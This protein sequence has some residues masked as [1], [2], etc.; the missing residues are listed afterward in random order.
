MRWLTRKK[1]AGFRGLESAG[2]KYLSSGG[3]MLKK[4]FLRRTAL[5][6]GGIPA[7]GFGR[8]GD[9]ASR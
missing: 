8:K 1:D 9:E 7:V 3:R 4:V 5:V 2:L 6:A